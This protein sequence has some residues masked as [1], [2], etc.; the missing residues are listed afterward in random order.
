M[1]VLLNTQ[2]HRAARNS[3]SIALADAGPNNATLR[4]YAAQGGALLGVRTLEKPCGSIRPTDGRLVLQAASVADVVVAT[5]SG[6]WGEWCDGSGFAISAGHV[7]DPAGNFT[8][9][10]GNVVPHPDGMGP[11][12]LGGSGGTAGGT[13]VYAGGLVLL[14]SGVIG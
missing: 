11:F 13:M 6:S 3:A 7:T 12:F 1:P 4:L 2:A 8:N 5:G 9:D 10:I 14:Y